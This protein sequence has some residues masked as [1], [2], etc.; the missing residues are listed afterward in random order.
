MSIHTKHLLQEIAYVV[1]TL[2][3]FAG[4]GVLLALGI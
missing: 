4:I 1:C 2:G 3:I